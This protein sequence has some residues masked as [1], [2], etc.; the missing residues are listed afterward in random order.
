M[1]LITPDGL[2]PQ[3]KE[4]LFYPNDEKGEILVFDLH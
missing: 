3:G 2:M 4:L 1:P